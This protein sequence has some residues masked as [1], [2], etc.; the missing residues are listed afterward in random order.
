M[1]KLIMTERKEEKMPSKYEYIDNENVGGY[2]WNCH[3]YFRDSIII[4]VWEGNCQ[5]YT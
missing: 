2:C 3:H 4:Q 1:Q 5:L